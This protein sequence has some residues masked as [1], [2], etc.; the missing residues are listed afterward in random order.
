MQTPCIAQTTLLVF[1]ACTLNAEL[2]SHD[3]AYDERLI[4][5][6]CPDL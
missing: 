5:V 1:P 4:A 3:L 2:T 6:Q